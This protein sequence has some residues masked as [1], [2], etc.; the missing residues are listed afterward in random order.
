MVKLGPSKTVL[1]LSLRR[2]ESIQGYL[3]SS[4]EG[5]GEFGDTEN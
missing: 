4:R 1:E 2:P 3:L 5:V